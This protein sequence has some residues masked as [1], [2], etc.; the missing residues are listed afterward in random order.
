MTV[1]LWLAAVILVLIAIAGVI[2]PGLPGLSISARLF[3]FS[4]MS[5]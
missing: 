2:F 5:R 3:S 4:L 1:L